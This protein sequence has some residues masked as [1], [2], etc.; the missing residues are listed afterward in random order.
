MDSSTIEQNLASMSRV[1]NTSR[2]SMFLALNSME[3]RDIVDSASEKLAEGISKE[4]VLQELGIE[5]MSSDDN[6][7]IGHVR[8]YFNTGEVPVTSDYTVTIE[9]YQDDYAVVGVTVSDS[10]NKD[11]TVHIRNGVWIQITINGYIYM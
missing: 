6:V 2:S 10:E 3:A 5:N 1:I 4:N 11:T 9:Q 7:I 8:K